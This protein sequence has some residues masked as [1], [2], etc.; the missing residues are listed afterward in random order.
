MLPGGL[1]L[2]RRGSVSSPVAAW[3]PIG[4]SRWAW[5]APGRLPTI[6]RRDMEQLEGAQKSSPASA[7]RWRW[8]GLELLVGCTSLP[9]ACAAPPPR[10]RD[11]ARAPSPQNPRICRVPLGESLIFRRTPSQT[12]SGRARQTER[13]LESHADRAVLLARR[14]SLRCRT[15]S[16]DLRPRRARGGR[17]R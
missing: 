5:N 1:R 13:S 14:A 3:T 2:G 4:A 16:P 9:A 12:H 6:V 10:W 15:A 7:L 11:F 8:F 17:Y